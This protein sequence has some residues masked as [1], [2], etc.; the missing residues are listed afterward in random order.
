[1]RCPMVITYRISAL[2]AWIYKKM[3]YL[4]WVGLPNILQ[5]R[6]FVP[7]LLQEDATPERLSTAMVDL[8][9]SPARRAEMARE[10]AAIHQKLRQ[11]SAVRAADAVLSCIR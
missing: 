9:R 10:F 2:S 1:M 3:R 5:G 4:P 11:D 7:E 6:L 8:W